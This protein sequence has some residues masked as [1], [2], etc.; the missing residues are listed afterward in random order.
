M[1]ADAGPAAAP[2]DPVAV[3]RAFL[4]ALERLD[5]DGALELTSPDIVYQ[6][7]P[8]PPVRGRVAFEQQM[9][10]LER[11]FTGFEAE[12]HHVAADG[13]SVLTERTDVLERGALR[14]AFW[15]DGTFEVLD[16]R[17]TVWRDRFDWVTVMVAVLAAVPRA[18]F[19][20]FRGTTPAA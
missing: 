11:Y 16:G 19:A 6:N 2:T 9:R 1:T 14:A 15:V 10:F 4:D 18:L 7:V 13:A 17:I 20:R 5:I 12:I 3:V 8:L